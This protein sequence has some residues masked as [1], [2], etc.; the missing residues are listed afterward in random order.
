MVPE[1]DPM[2][3]EREA[4]EH[5]VSEDCWQVLHDLAI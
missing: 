1:E 2:R 3:A 5:M 4:L